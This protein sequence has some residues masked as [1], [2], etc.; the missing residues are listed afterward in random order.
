MLLAVYIFVDIDVQ[1]M[2]GRELILIDFPIPG[3]PKRITKP[4]KAPEMMFLLFPFLFA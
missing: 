2:G 1:L 3:L 4:K